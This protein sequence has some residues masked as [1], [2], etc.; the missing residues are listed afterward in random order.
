M[1]QLLESPD[2]PADYL[3][4]VKTFATV[5]EDCRAASGLNWT[6]PAPSLMIAPGARTGDYRTE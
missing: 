4:E 5:L 6:M 2:F 3:P 1:F